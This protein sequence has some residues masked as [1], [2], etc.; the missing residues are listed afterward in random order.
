MLTVGAKSSLIAC[1]ILELIK[2][3][4]LFTSITETILPHFFHDRIVEHGIILLEITTIL[5]RFNT[6]LQARV[7]KQSIFSKTSQRQKHLVYLN[8]LDIK[9]F[10]FLFNPSFV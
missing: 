6:N 9:V 3:E 1:Y 10:V 4:K 8:A 2:R 7:L 5:L